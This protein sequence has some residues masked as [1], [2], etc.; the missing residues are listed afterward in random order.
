[1][2]AIALRNFRGQAPR[3]SDRSLG[4]SQATRARNCKVASGKLVPLKGLFLRHQA[5][6][7][8]LQTVYRY[9]DA[10]GLDHWLVWPSRVH[11]AASPVAGDTAGRIYFTGAGEPR[12]TTAAAAIQGAED[13]P[14]GWFVLGVAAPAGTPAVAASGGSS[15]T[16]EVRTYVYTFRTALGEESGPSPASPAVTGKIDDT[17]TVSNMSVAPP[18]IG[19]VSGAVANTPAVGQVRVTLNT[20]V[21]LAAGEVIEFDGVAGMTALNGAQTILAVNAGSVDVALA[22]SQ[23]YT[24]GGTWARQA[25]H[26]TAGMTKRIYRTKGSS[27]FLFVAEVPVATTSYADTVAATA[28]GDA[29]QTLLTLP[30]PKDLRC[31][32]VL[33]NGAM[34][35]ISGNELCFSEQNKPHSWPIGSRYAFAGE[36]VALT[37]VGNS[38]ILLT[39]SYPIIA[40]ATVPEAANLARSEVYAPCYS[41]PGTVDSGA[42]AIFPSYDGLYEVTPGGGPRNITE[43]LF[44][45]DEWEA[46]FP[47]TFTAAYHDQTYIAGH[48]SLVAPLS[49]V[50]TLDLT[51]PDGTIDIDERADL[52][53]AN[54]RDGKLYLVQGGSIYEWDADPENPYTGFWRSR[55]YQ[56]GADTNFSCFR[57]HADLPLRSTTSTRL[58]RAQQQVQAANAALLAN[59][60]A[61]DGE[62]AGSV[63]GGFEINGSE[64]V[65]VNQTAPPW[66][67]ADNLTLMALEP[68][69]VRGWMLGQE[70][71]S[72]DINGSNLRRISRAVEPR[73]DFSLLV[74]GETAFTTR[75]PVSQMDRLPSGFLSNIYAVEVSFNVPVYSIAVANDIDELSSDFA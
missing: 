63:L 49:Q 68:D 37:V 67:E 74:D 29:I 44:R 73:V 50:L 5:L 71:N 43:G 51:Q 25:P 53:Y 61:V 56:L 17:W 59:P 60:N 38:V 11:V 13:Y 2:T 40:T 15:S 72:L 7:L 31:L 57:V 47:R 19:T 18:N 22:T 48:A 30:P 20:V 14:A 75:V 24:S 62:L 1:M 21:G 8:A 66:S 12:M 58:T 54:P 10:G 26:N 6:E 9:R 45:K 3:L 35:G 39:D 42:G 28:L 23:V 36:G 34:V 4:A 27:E 69:R 41:E 46:L 65:P 70:I 52:F 32:A 64:L 55:T 33:A 16:T